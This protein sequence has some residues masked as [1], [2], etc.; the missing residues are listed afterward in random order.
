MPKKKKA[1]QQD[2][3]QQNEAYMKFFRAIDSY[4]DI[5]LWLNG[6]LRKLYTNP[7]KY[8]KEQILKFIENPNQFSK[9]LRQLHQYLMNTSF[10]YK[11]L[12]YY[13]ASMLTFDYFLYPI[14]TNFDDIDKKSF[15]K[16]FRK[17]LDFTEKFNIKDEF[18]R[19]M[20]VILGE[21]VGYYYLRENNGALT[22]QRMP[23]DYCMIVN[24]NE[25]GFQYAINLNYFSQPGINIKNYP[26]EIQNAYN[27]RTEYPDG[28]FTLSFENAIAF[29]FEDTA[30]ILPI[31]MGLYADILD[32]FEY[33]EMFKD[34]SALDA[35]QIIAQRIPMDTKS[36]KPDALLI[37][38]DKAEFFH[39][40]IKK[41]L[42][43]NVKVVTSPMDIN[44]ILVKKEENKDNI[45]GQAMENFF[46]SAGVSETLFGKQ[47][48]GSVGLLQSII[49][50]AS[51]VINCYRQFERWINYQLS[52]R[53]GRYKFKIC[54]PDITSFNWKDK[55]DKYLK[56]AEFGYSKSTV[57]CAMGLT[58]TQFLGLNYLENTLDMVNILQPLQSSHTQSGTNSG[59]A[60]QKDTDQLTDNGLKTRDNK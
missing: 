12:V 46:Q 27:K 5:P 18:S 54:F 7:Y 1:S 58:P 19:V 6:A 22:L 9:E 21:D 47:V 31:F 11:R 29:K 8:T 4:N 14:D 40:N 17:T 50:D 25:V 10:H 45:V 20:R 48:T 28:W 26:L 16:S 51:F 56:A 44:S 13:F 24:K 60:P 35:S 59:G 2:I 36:S 49:V 33:K 55:F 30:L 41:G 38:L 37:S 32:I 39:N 53:I 15:Q 42:P 3:Q 43:P 34:K 23:S 52:K 57:A